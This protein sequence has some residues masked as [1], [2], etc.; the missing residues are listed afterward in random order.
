MTMSTKAAG[1]SE[2]SRRI[3][4]NTLLLYFRMLLL[5]L[6]GLFTSRVVLD[7][8]GVEDYGVYNAVGGAVA[9]FTFIS[10][11]ISSAISRFITV[12]LG[13]GDGVRLRRVFCTGVLIQ[14]ALSLIV[15]LLAETV[16][17]WFLR[18][19]MVIPPGRESAAFTVLQCSLGVLV[20]NMLSVPY[21]ATIIAHERMS[22]F[23]LI[24]VL[25]AVL[26]LSVALLL[27]V[28]VFDKLET[29]AFL[30]LAVSLVVRGAYSLYCRRHFAE[31]SGPLV[32][33][34]ALARE[35]S[36]FAGW[37]FF[38]TGAYV[39]N[40]QG[41]SLVMN[42]FFGVALNA[43]RGIAFQVEGIV[44]Q[45]VSGFLTALNP[46]ITKSWASGDREYC[47][48]LVRKGAK[49]AYLV[50]FAFFVPFL[51]ES[52]TLLGLWLVEVPP[53]AADFVRLALLGLMI[54]LTGNSLLTLTLATGRVRNYYLITGL[55]SY[56]C[57][58]LVYLAFRLGA[59]PQWAY[60][61]F[62]IIYFA[63]LLI[64]LLLVR[65]LTLFPPG[66]FLRAVVLPL[67]E[68]S[69]CSVAIPLVL[70]LLLPQGLLRLILICAAGWLSMGL[71]VFVFALTPGERSF[72]TRKLGRRWFPDRIAVEDRYFEVMGKRP[73]LKAPRRYNEKLQWQKLYDR[74]PLYHTLA[75]KAEVKPYVAALIGGEHII[76]TLGVWERAEDIDWDALPEKFVLKCT[77]DSGSSIVCTDKAAFDRGA[78]IAGLSACLR[79]NFWICDREWVYKG[80]K[81]R[82][83]A[84][85][86][87]GD[88][89]RDYKFFCFGGR[90]EVMY[91]ASDRASAS[92]ETKYDFFDMEYRR[93]DIRNV[94]PN[95]AV[96]PERPQS[97]G[98]MKSLAAKL[99]QGIPQVRVDFYE[100]EGRVL[101]GEYTFYHGGG[102][103]PFEPDSADE[104]MGGFFKLPAR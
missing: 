13:R 94:H 86:Y 93:L 41:I 101:F 87:I 57:L 90:P 71:S 40:T 55:V 75:D 58:P 72:V 7:A 53:F 28:S 65:R 24:S 31:S 84:E 48:E 66:K 103:E 29:Y 99:S 2:G 43:A 76:P 98:E 33:D 89:I 46:Q 92:E 74:N 21:N 73:D 68:V 17:I 96:P 70:Y 50:I 61:G 49:Y 19:K 54:D 62:I 9:L 10:A 51:F 79:R 35:M 85:T 64:R 8:L 37:S 32:Y 80:V 5:I 77:H 45:F 69:L 60:I 34:A 23:A 14:L 1:L 26:K 27:Y 11:S 59:P 20:V 100:V 12:E 95:S 22:A 25:E 91:V 6:I 16:G 4:K 47:F 42:I 82:I 88:D 3:A 30:T 63:V 36:G 52:D 67:A 83:I 44:R 102:L 18:E 81:P 39:F 78:A 15:I 97:F 38:G 104:W 56:L